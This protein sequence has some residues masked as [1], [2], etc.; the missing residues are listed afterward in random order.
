MQRAKTFLFALMTLMLLLVGTYVQGALGQQAQPQRNIIVTGA[1]EIRSEG[2]AASAGLEA[3]I[4]RVGP[5]LVLRFVQRLREQP[6]VSTPDGL[7]T[8]LERVV[9]RIVLRFPNRVRAQQLV[10][11]PAELEA[12][13]EQLRKRFV[14]RFANRLRVVEL[15]CPEPIMPCDTVLPV[16]S[17][18]TEEFSSKDTM[19]I[20]WETDEPA[21][22]QVA[23]GTQP[24]NYSE[25]ESRHELVTSHE[26]SLTSLAPGTYFYQL[27]STDASG[28]TASETGQFSIECPEYHAYLPILLKR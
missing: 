25:I 3:A 21:D 8:N 22:S 1:D 10:D 14:L 9:K 18:V 23:H 11:I 28:N 17:N 13:L 12:R 15:A 4:E 5:R 27:S 2:P 7:Q 20:R 26:I 6:L 24:G 19:A 16:I